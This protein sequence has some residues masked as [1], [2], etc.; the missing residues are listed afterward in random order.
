MVSEQ[1]ARREHPY[2]DTVISFF[3]ED[4][5]PESV[6]PYKGALVITAQVRAIDMRR[7]MIENGSS[8][9]ILYTRAYQRLDLE[10]RKME[11]GQEAPP[12][13]F[14]NDPMNVVGTIVLLVTFGTT[15]QHV[16]IDIKFFVVQVDSTYNVILGRTT[17]AAL[18]A[19]TSIPHFKMKFPTPNG[20]EEVK[21]D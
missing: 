10:G 9:D 5:P 12:Y 18:Q 4:Y 19:V 14:S 3:D 20:V 16:Q 21:G 17:L 7:I 13:G 1:P 2:P 8:V 6:E 11:A 15:P